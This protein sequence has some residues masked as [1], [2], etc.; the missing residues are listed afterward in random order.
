MP[1]KTN[2]GRIT[3]KKIVRKRP[4][5]NA[6]QAIPSDN[7]K[8]QKR[9]A[10]E[11]TTERMDNSSKDQD[12]T[13]AEQTARIYESTEK[14]SDNTESS[15][16]EKASDDSEGFG[17]ANTAE[18]ATNE[19]RKQDSIGTGSSSAKTCT[20][21]TATPINIGD[22]DSE[23]ESGDETSEPQ[24]PKQ[25]QDMSNEFEVALWV[26]KHSRILNLALEIQKSKSTQITSANESPKIL[27]ARTTTMPQEI[28]QFKKFQLQEECKALFIRT[29]N[30]TQELYEELVMR[31]CNI[32]KTD[33]RMG[34]LVK[35]V[36]GW[37][38]TYRYKL[39]VG[40]VK[41]A[42]DFNTLHK[43]VEDYDELLKEFISEEVWKQ[44]LHMHLKAVDQQKF[45]K[46]R[47]IISKLGLFCDEY[48]IDLNIPTKLGIVGSLAVRDLLDF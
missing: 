38:N 26:A 2:K 29:R 22:S 44:L 11:E 42:N 46:N 28:D 41:L 20:T 21:T 30:N 12:T 8:Q 24:R 9:P 39:H 25:F 36:A 35:D 3:S 23:E 5:N 43:D 14:T 45:K 6:E 31:V 40:V 4:F 34:A 37:Y 10:E 7:S 1:K 48:T 17:T 32:S 16:N 27:P 18:P 13:T 47:E 15:G 19:R 33:Q